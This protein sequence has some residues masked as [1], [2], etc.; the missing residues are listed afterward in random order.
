MSATHCLRVQTNGEGET[1]AL[2]R[3][4][5]QRLKTGIFVGLSGPLGAGKTVLASGMLEGA[6]VPGPHRSPTFTLVW[7]HTGH[8][9]IYHVD[10][11]RLSPEEASDDLPWDRLLSDR[12]VA[13]VEWADRL[14]LER[15]IVD[16][17]DI[18]IAIP[19]GSVSG[20][21]IRIRAFGLGTCI[22]PREETRPCS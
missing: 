15:D 12:S 13:I 11:Y 10:L 2:G 22:L 9:P 19:G 3:R 20:R 5:G 21:E 7:E 4:I 18:H 6:G 14:P 8:F 16:R 17:V 1:R